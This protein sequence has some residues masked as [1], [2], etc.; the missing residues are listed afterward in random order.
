MHRKLHH[1]SR[2][3]FNPNLAINVTII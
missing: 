2:L 3:N 1:R